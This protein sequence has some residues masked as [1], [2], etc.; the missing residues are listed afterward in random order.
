MTIIPLPA[1]RQ[2]AAEQSRHVDDLEGS[3]A[4]ALAAAG[5]LVAERRRLQNLRTDLA[6]VYSLAGFG[7]RKATSVRMQDAND[8]ID[9]I[10]RALDALRGDR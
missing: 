1:A 3:F 8:A 2:E 7:F 5:V 9:A 4:N 6:R 10:D